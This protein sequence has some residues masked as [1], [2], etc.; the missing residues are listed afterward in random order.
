MLK[1]VKDLRDKKGQALVMAYVVLIFL[2]I[3]VA[4][5][6]TKA[7][8]EYRLANRQRMFQEAFY[9]A[10][11]GLED[12]ICEFK[13]AIANFDVE[14]HIAIWPEQ[15][16]PPV[17]PPVPHTTTYSSFHNATVNSIVVRMEDADRVVDIESGAQALVRNYEVI[18]T[19][20]HPLSS[21]IT[22]TLHQIVARKL[23]PAFQ[24][25]VFYEND[26]E[27]LP[28]PDMKFTGRVHSN[29][30][31][32]LGCHNTLTLDSFYLHSAAN[33]YNRR[34]NDDSDMGGTVDI[35][36]TKPE[37]EPEEYAAMDE[38]D[39]DAPAWEVESQTRWQGTVKS[40]IHG[41]TKI[42]APQVRSVQ[43]D[44]YYSSQADVKITNDTITQGGTELTPGVDIPLNTV[45]SSTT[46]YNN[47]EEKTVKM[48]DIDLQKLAGY[49]TE[50]EYN[51]DTP[52]FPNHL[53][54][55]GLIYA[56]RDDAGGFYQ[57]GIR[58]L[59][60][61]EI[62]RSGGLTVVTNDPLYIQGSYN[63]ED[64][65]PAA[66]ICDALNLLSD[67]WNNDDRS[68]SNLNYRPAAE[69]SFNTAFVAGID[70]TVWGEYNG[71]L[72]NYPRMHENWSGRDLNIRGAF[73][74]LWNSQIAQGEWIYGNPQ[75]TAPNR[76]WDYDTDFNDSS[77]LPP[78]TPWA[79]E[80]ERI[81]WWKE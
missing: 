80:T 2:T 76:K 28:G 24:H 75:Y 26:L 20:Q 16:E 58:L 44:G 14:P 5:F 77:K 52:S 33:I 9:L 31:I 12:T 51:N 25:A 70:E 1:I 40:A 43:P 53:P 54:D 30:D 46:F 69:T 10:E 36:I 57:P 61:E 49:A 13:Q 38:L 22:V 67:A 11:G 6:L 29:R 62:E 45:S 48:T 66:V 39:S 32:Y 18:T 23:I 50:E 59:K 63:T 41:V 68:H 71:G 8:T 42:A 81:V 74:A 56:T 3:L 72:E 19:A 60:G 73:L 64:K 17:E 79:V 4:A 34:K 21:G 55:N 27:L 7:A 15:P 37:G 65:K 78:F 35:R 47:R